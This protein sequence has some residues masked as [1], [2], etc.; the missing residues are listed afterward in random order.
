VRGFRLLPSSFCPPSRSASYEDLA[1]DPPYPRQPIFSDGRPR[2]ALSSVVR[3]LALFSLTFYLSHWSP[4]GS[5]SASS[6]STGEAR[7]SSVVLDPSSF[8]ASLDAA[9]DLGMFR[10]GTRPLVSPKPLTI[11]LEPS[12]VLP[13]PV[14]EYGVEIPLQSVDAFLLASYQP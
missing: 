8:P 1:S 6:V 10:T 14:D 11:F 5:P 12:S 9:F 7:V 13:F 2:R 3:S 4:S